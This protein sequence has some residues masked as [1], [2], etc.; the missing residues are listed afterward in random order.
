MRQKFNKCIAVALLASAGLAALPAVADN[1]YTPQT[2]PRRVDDSSGYL[3]LTG[4]VII[5]LGNL[6]PG[7]HGGLGNRIISVSTGPGSSG[8]IRAKTCV[9]SQTS[10]NDNRNTSYLRIATGPYYDGTFVYNLGSSGGVEDSTSANCYYDGVAGFTSSPVFN[11]YENQASTSNREYSGFYART[12]YDTTQLD[13]LTG[14]TKSLGSSY[15]SYEY[16]PCEVAP[17]SMAC[18][19]TIVCP[20]GYVSYQGTCY[21]IDTGGSGGSG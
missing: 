20:A 8:F 18:Y 14:A 3:T 17:Q 1:L 10:S 5:G 6:P 21:P 12:R 13:F 11:N 9:L 19:E 4:N 2:R 7:A 16:V 15:S